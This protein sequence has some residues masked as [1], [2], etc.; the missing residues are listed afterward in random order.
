MESMHLSYQNTIFR[1]V[2]LKYKDFPFVVS[3][4][5]KNEITHLET[6]FAERFDDKL[7]DYYRTKIYSLPKSD[8]AFFSEVDHLAAWV[9]IADKYSCKS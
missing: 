2:S 6:S 7:L 5:R 8:I 4:M 9:F 3:A 1:G